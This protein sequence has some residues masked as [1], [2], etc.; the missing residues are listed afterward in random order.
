MH[1]NY[2]V[3][4]KQK[5]RKDPNA[6]FAWSEGN[7][8]KFGINAP[9]VLQHTGEAVSLEVY[10]IFRWDPS[11]GVIGEEP[12]T[13]MQM[14]KE[15]WKQ[16]ESHKNTKEASTK[17]L[18]DYARHVKLKQLWN[19]NRSCW[20]RSI[21]MYIQNC[22]W[23]QQM[24]FHAICMLGHIGSENEDTTLTFVITYLGPLSMI[25]TCIM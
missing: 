3:R 20:K 15:I 21:L 14:E 9:A 8:A 10:E 23:M 1:L 18:V 12:M 24:T 22:G 19:E 4:I 25:H 5:F 13:I 6:E 16:H 7:N 11:N 2:A 17:M